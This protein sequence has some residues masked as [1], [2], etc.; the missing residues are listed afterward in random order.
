MLDTR[1][2]RGGDGPPAMSDAAP[3]L[4]EWSAT[5]PAI[6]IGDTIV[7]L[8]QYAPDARAA[9]ARFGVRYKVHSVRLG[10]RSR[11]VTLVVYVQEDVA[12]G[13]RFDTVNIVS[14]GP[15]GSGTILARGFGRSDHPSV[16]VFKLN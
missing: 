16:L 5:D 15:N 1:L 13:R 9:S 7:Y 2:L 6:R 8:T 3:L 11:L 14:T 4:G 10:D 12:T